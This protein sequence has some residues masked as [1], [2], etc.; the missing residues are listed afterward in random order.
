M[1]DGLPAP[2]SPGAFPRVDDDRQIGRHARRE[3]VTRGLHDIPGQDRNVRRHGNC[4]PVLSDRHRLQRRIVRQKPVEH[5]IERYAVEGL[6][7]GR[8]RRIGNPCL[9]CHTLKSIGIC[10]AVRKEGSRPLQISA[11][12][13]SEPS[14]AVP[15]RVRSFK[16]IQLLSKAPARVSRLTVAQGL[17]LAAWLE[18]A[19]GPFGVRGAAVRG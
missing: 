15:A 5:R 9:Q 1:N 10:D 7:I 16:V 4:E 18:F 14:I 8:A 2:R 3:W 11:Q 13:A 17:A 19:R 6:F 12:L